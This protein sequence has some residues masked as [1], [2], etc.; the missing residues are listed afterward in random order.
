MKIEDDELVETHIV[1]AE[2]KRTHKLILEIPVYNGESV[3]E[4]LDRIGN[5]ERLPG[6][7][8]DW[9]EY[10]RL[11]YEHIDR[12]SNIVDENDNPVWRK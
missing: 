2:P 4:T 3:E 10:G 9:K 5:P 1:D 7:D 11:L 12:H 8:I 6:A